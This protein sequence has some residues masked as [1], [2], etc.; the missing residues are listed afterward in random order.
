MAGARV[1]IGVDEAAAFRSHRF[2]SAAGKPVAWLHVGVERELH[3]YGSPRGDAPVRGD[4][5]HG[6][7]RG[8]RAARGARR[9]A[10]GERVVMAIDDLLDR[11]RD[12][13]RRRDESAG[14]LAALVRALDGLA[15]VGLLDAI[16]RRLRDRPRGVRTAT[17]RAARERTMAG[18]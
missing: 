7:R 16:Q 1:S 11:A 2:V 3:V 15:G 4:G 14:E 8:G 18:G 13:R 10:G 17:R 6:G 5:D 9:V 12:A